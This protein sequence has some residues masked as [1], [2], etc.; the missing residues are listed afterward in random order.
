[1]THDTRAGTIQ[2]GKFR[3]FYEEERGRMAGGDKGYL[4]Q[5]RAVIRL[6]EDLVKIERPEDYTV[7]CDEA[8][9]RKGSGSRPSALQYFIA[10]IGFCMLS[11]LAR[12][13]AKLSVSL[14][15]AEMDLRMTYGLKAKSRLTDCATAAQSLTYLLKIQSNAPAEQVIRLARSTDKGCH[16]VNSLR[17]WVPVSGKLLLNEKEYSILD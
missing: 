17:K 4:L 11:Q 1:V 13:A 8:N 12:F 15:D 7:L 3:I 2:L 14:D 5:Q 10:S 16:T 9:F 6:N